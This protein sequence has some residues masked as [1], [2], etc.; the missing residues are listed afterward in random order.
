MIPSAAPEDS[1]PPA[2][3][4]EMFSTCLEPAP[5]LLQEEKPA[6][7]LEEQQQEASPEEG[8]PGEE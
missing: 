8:S 7:L 1:I 2:K 5:E 3:E 6:V 4:P